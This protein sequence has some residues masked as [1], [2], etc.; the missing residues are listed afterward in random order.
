VGKGWDLWGLP[1]LWPASTVKKIFDKVSRPSFA[2]DICSAQVFA[3]NS[4]A[5][6]LNSAKEGYG[7]KD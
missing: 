4:D 6:E 5:H 3:N 1:A 7:Y 2:F